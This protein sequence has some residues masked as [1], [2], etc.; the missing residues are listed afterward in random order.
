MW[1]G[2]KTLDC[3]LILASFVQNPVLKRK[4]RALRIIKHY[5]DLEIVS[6][7]AGANE[8]AQYGADVR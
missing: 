7:Q 3:F 4:T 6:G 8:A 1:A 2:S 5:A